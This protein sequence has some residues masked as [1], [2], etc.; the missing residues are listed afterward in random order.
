MCPAKSFYEEFGYLCHKYF[1]NVKIKP[2]YTYDNILM[3]INNIPYEYC[4][5][6]SGLE[7]ILPDY[8]NLLVGRFDDIY[9]LYANVPFKFTFRVINKRDGI[10]RTRDYNYINVAG[11]ISTTYAYNEIEDYDDK[12]NELYLNLGLP[13]ERFV[14]DDYFEKIDNTNLIISSIIM[15]KNK[16]KNYVTQFTKLDDCLSEIKEA[17]KNDEFEPI[18]RNKQSLMEM[19]EQ[20]SKLN[21]ENKVKKM[22]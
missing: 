19:N 7:V 18:I 1:S 15:D 17:A 5:F 13:L 3:S 2:Y 8:D 10:V 22:K 4:S 6:E 14:I 12:L 9:I 11:K 16:L 21:I 20:I